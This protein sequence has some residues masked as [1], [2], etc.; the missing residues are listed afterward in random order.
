MESVCALTGYQGFESLPLRVLLRQPG[1]VLGAAAQLRQD[2]KV[3]AVSG[4]PLCRRLLGWRF[5]FPLAL[6]RGDIFR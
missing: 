2:R 5:Y 1:A 3:A 4:L 6:N